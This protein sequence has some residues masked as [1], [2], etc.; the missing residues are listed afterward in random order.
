MPT[1]SHFYHPSILHPSRHGM[2]WTLWSCK[3]RLLNSH[4]FATISCSADSNCKWLIIRL[5]EGKGMNDHR[6]KKHPQISI[7]MIC[8]EY[9]VCM[10][11]RHYIKG[12]SGTTWVKR[13]LQ[14]RWEMESIIEGS[15]KEMLNKKHWNLCERGKVTQCNTSRHATRFCTH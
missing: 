8:T 4:N 1:A 11:Q 13:H 3:Y 12:A 2:A 14:L 6:N 7:H 10:Y 5:V 15:H 9:D